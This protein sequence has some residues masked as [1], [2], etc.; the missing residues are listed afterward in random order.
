MNKDEVFD[1]ITRH[2]REVL[3]ELDDHEF[4]LDD[5]LRTLGANSIDRSEIVMLTLATLSLN[6]PLVDLAGA[7]NIGEL[8]GIIHERC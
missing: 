2:T 4:T 6:I 3:P 1:I 5:S 7:Q 8:A